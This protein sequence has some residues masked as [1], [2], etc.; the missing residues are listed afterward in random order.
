MEERMKLKIM[1]WNIKGAAALGWDK[2]DVIKSKA[3][4]AVIEQKADVI[5]LTEFVVGKGLDYL[6]ER[7]HDEKYI[8]FI[9]SCSGKNG[10]LIAIKENLLVEEKNSLEKL[11]DKIYKENRISS[12]IEDCNILKVTVPLKCDKELCIIGCRMET[13]LADKDKNEYDCRKTRFE[14]ILVPQIPD[15][16]AQELCIVCGDFNNA[17]HYGSLKAKFEE[18]EEK[19][20]T[21]DWDPVKKK[22]VGEKYKRAQYN[23]NLHTIKDNLGKNGFKLCELE[24]DFTHEK[25]KQK[26][27][28]DHIF[29]RGFNY[30]ER[31]GVV[32]PE[33]G[34]S[35][36][37]IL[38]AEVE[39]KEE[40]A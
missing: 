32:I 31:S 34:M 5:V 13:S 17:K 25:Y 14:Q 2:R 12:V 6:L 30:E 20:W 26:I 39:E 24:D 38:W 21:Q 37:N 35:D 3:V 19:Y 10:I 18:V 7:L 22:Y 33:K 9:S 28:E 8:W 4:D 15:R 40:K 27:H 36:H 23:Y 16:K 11:K 29:V 1:T